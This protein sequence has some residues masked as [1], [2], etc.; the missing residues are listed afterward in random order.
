MH[1][2]LRR[3]IYHDLC[4][5]FDR[6]HTIE[7]HELNVVTE[8]SKFFIGDKYDKETKAVTE[9]SDGNSTKKRFRRWAFQTLYSYCDKG[10]QAGEK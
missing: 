10:G 1:S 4:L 7:H 5:L 9:K 6:L 2:T 8:T 3:G